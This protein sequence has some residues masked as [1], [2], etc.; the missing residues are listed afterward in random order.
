MPKIGN[1]TVEELSQ[2]VQENILK[3]DFNTALSIINKEISTNTSDYR[4]YDILHRVYWNKRDFESAISSLEKALEINPHAFWLKARLARLCIQRGRIEDG[5]QLYLSVIKQKPEH[6]GALCELAKLERKENQIETSDEYFAKAINA[7]IKNDTPIRTAIIQRLINKRNYKNYLEIGV[8]SGVNFFQITT[9]YK[10]AIDPVFTIPGDKKS[11]KKSD[12]FYEVTS[13]AFFE[14]DN[15]VTNGNKVID[16][17]LIDGMHTYEQSKLDVLN[18]LKYLSDDGIII[19]HDCYPQNEAAA[20]PDMQEAIKTPGFTG[21]W[22][23]DVWKTVVWFRANRRDLTTFTLDTDNGLGII[24]KKK[25]DKELDYTD[26][27]I[28]NMGYKDFLKIGP[29]DLLGLSDPKEFMTE[30][31]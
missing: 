26:E 1:M 10:V 6:A 27:D 8:Q 12:N 24:S 9:D 5:K 20:N 31:L 13:D 16:I 23:G 25:S 7:H 14:N 19:M 29:T 3:K 28:L 17:A 18:T 4:Y 21:A 30:H 2:V 11:I 22:N 15:P